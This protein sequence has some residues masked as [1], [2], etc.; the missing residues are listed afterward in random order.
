MVDWVNDRILHAMCR[1]LTNTRLRFEEG[2][3]NR[4]AVHKVPDGGSRGEIA[5]AKLQMAG[6]KQCSPSAGERGR[7]PKE[8]TI[9]KKTEVQVKWDKNAEHRE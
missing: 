2:R 7:G 9:E 8:R 6:R 4:M 3:L 5:D 1:R